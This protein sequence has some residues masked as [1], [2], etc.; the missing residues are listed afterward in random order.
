MHHTDEWKPLIYLLWL[1]LWINFFRWCLHTVIVSSKYLHFIRQKSKAETIAEEN[2]KRLKTK[3]EK[4]EQEQ[5]KALCVPTEKEIKANLTVGVNNLEKFLKTLKSKSVKF[6]VEM[7]GLSACLE[8]WKE[9]CRQQGM[10]A[11]LMFSIQLPLPLTKRVSDFG[12]SQ[13]E[14]RLVNTALFHEHER[15]V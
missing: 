7:T 9:H 5:W 12:H 14:W 1:S 4:K 3:E 15:C 13:L 8:V 11:K 10:I 6:S 2:I